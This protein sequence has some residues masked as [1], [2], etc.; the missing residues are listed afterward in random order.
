[1]KVLV[2]GGGGREHALVWKIAQSPRVDEIVAAPGNAGI[3]ELARCASVAADDIAG[4]VDL[5]RTERADL[6]V[7]GPEL[8][9]TLGLVDRLADSGIAAFGP[10]AA[11][12]RLEGSKGFAKDVMTRAG[13]PTAAA[14]LTEDRD[15]A[16]ARA[17]ELGYP[18]VVKADGLAAGKGV[19][20]AEDAAAAAR[21]V[22]DA[23]IRG[24]FGAAGSSVLIEEYLEGQEASI[25]AFTDGDTIASLVPSQDHKRALDGDEGPNTGGMGA[26]APAP[27]V[28]AATLLSIEETVIRPVVRT[29]NGEGITYRGVLYA[30]LMMTDDGPKVLEFNCRFG[31]PETQVVLPLLDG[32]LFE[33]MLA[34]VRGELDPSMVLIKPGAAACV[35]MA[36]GG[37]PGQYKK[38]SEI[39]GLEG[40]RALDDVV[41]F[42]A[43]TA[44]RDGAVVT[45]GGRVLGVTATGADLPGAISRAYEGVRAVTF[46]GAHFRTD[47]GHRALARLGTTEGLGA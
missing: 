5:A 29:L 16:I 46:E 37:Y 32:D 42:H 36:S 7:V 14:R 12:A 4:L 21:A 45:S 28:D 38:G 6:V 34:T 35:V 31:D 43:G 24:R 11:A 33:I 8:P 26:Y 19:V 2:V 10:S 39:R 1:M 23:L 44:I 9:L 3:A 15:E 13:V 20:I 25:L 22:D 17:N 18:V 47:I 40:A 30:G 41:V 27:V